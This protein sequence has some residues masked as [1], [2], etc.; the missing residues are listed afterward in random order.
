MDLGKSTLFPQSD[1]YV[2]IT[3]KADFEYLYWA[4]Y[5]L[6]HANAFKQVSESYLYA[7]IPLT[8]L[9]NIIKRF[10]ANLHFTFKEW[11]IFLSRIRKIERTERMSRLNNCPA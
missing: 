7:P 1:S 9:N 4:C 10:Q 8:E 3:R 2:C 6:W 11:D 5:Y